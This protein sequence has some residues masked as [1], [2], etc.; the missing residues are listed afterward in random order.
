MHVIIALNKKKTNKRMNAVTYVYIINII[1]INNA[2]LQ[3]LP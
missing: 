1:I 2:V 3:C